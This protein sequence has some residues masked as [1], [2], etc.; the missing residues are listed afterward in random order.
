MTNSVYSMTAFASRQQLLANYGFVT[1]EVKAVNSKFL[2]LNIKLPDYLTSFEHAVRG[3]VSEKLKRGK[4]D[5]SVYVKLD[6]KF[7]LDSLYNEQIA[8][9]LLLHSNIKK[10]ADESSITTQ[11][12]SISEIIKYLNNQGSFR[13]QLNKNTEIQEGIG[14]IVKQ[15]LEQLLLSRSTEGQGLKHVMLAL[16]SE[17]KQAIAK[18]SEMEPIA[19]Q[20]LASKFSAK[21]QDVTRSFAETIGDNLIPSADLES[22]VAQ[23]I[24]IYLNKMDIAE[25]IA[26]L[27][28]HAEE[29][30]N[31]LEQG[32]VIGRKLDFLMQEL[33]REANTLAAKSVDIEFRNTAISIKLLIEQM[34]EQIQ[35]I[36]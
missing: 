19:K 15:A 27:K 31:T 7:K 28:L 22:K 6:A 26:R 18:L 4:V 12:L 8:E 17:T 1:V 23:E 33:M 24:A 11:E 36:E 25:E 2:D 34:R 21:L 10:L 16:L 14:G 30:A 35:N 13:Q 5:V 32:G 3:M 29:V 20:T 9:Y